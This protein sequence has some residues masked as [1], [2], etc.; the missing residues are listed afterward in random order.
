MKF[1]SSFKVIFGFLAILLMAVISSVYHIDFTKF[2]NNV[3][4]NLTND[5]ST[6]KK[7]KVSLAGCIDGD[8]AMFNEDGNTYT[9][10]FLGINTPEVKD[11]PEEYGVE[12]SIYTCNKLKSADNIYI[13]YEKTSTHTDKY[14]RHLVW[15]YV[16]N[17][18]LQ[19][20]LLENGLAKVQYVYTK[21]TYLDKLYK[22]E[23]IA[24]DKKIGIFKKYKEEIYKDNT[25]TVIFKNGNSKNE[26][27]VKEGS[28][29][30]I[31]NNP[32]GDTSFSGWIINGNLF[33]LSKPITNDIILDASFDNY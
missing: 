29:V 23:N 21:L 32:K 4:N 20:L 27:N 15:V 9:Y 31:I 14:D 25:Y 3:N 12:A 13:S 8:T 6:T 28:R 17:D 24:K 7:I 18:L 2:I 26:V 22:A 1:S 11:N 16:D 5:S 33:D 30:D 19:T 10:R